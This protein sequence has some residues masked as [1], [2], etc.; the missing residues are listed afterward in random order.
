MEREWIEHTKAR[1]VRGAIR[2]AKRVTVGMV[3]ADDVM[4]LEVGKTR[5][6]R[7]LKEDASIDGQL[8]AMEWPDEG[9]VH[10]DRA[11]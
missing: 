10:I 6:L 9:L 4:H 7:Q 2:R 8:M 5:L 11:M 1:A 3:M